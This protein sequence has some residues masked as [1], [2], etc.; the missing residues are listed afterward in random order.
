VSY[1][2]NEEKSYHHRAEAVMEA[3]V[4]AQAYINAAETS[5]TTIAW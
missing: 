5:R 4:E 3:A 1:T 2:I